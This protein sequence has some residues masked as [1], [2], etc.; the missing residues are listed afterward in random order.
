MTICSPLPPHL[1]DPIERI[2]DQVELI[3]DGAAL[4]FEIGRN[5]AL[6]RA[7]LD[8]M[9]AEADPRAVLLLVSAVGQLDAADAMRDRIRQGHELSGDSE[10]G[11]DD[12]VFDAWDSLCW[13]AAPDQ[14]DGQARAVA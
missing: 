1:Q 11:I 9:T 12:L 14:V 13:L 4:H 7:L 5:A 6:A 10:R 2:R 3:V 8:P